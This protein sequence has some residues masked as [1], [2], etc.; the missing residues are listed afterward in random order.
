MSNGEGNAGRVLVELARRA[1]ETFIRERRKID[2]PDDMVVPGKAGVFVSIKKYNQLRGC[3]G[4]LLPVTDNV[5]GEVV[6]NAISAATRDPRFDPVT[7]E[8]L[9]ELEI[10]VDVLSSPE[11]VEDITSLDP[12]RFGVIVRSGGKTG[13]LLPDLEGI[14]KAE[15]QVAIARRK[16][17]IGK[18]DPVELFRFRVAR[19]T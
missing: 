9:D 5:S 14:E 1:I 15:D 16:A 17:G 11:L 7:A 6:E 4:T 3:I 13:V 19:H 2:P 8:E 10:S 18:D 12:S